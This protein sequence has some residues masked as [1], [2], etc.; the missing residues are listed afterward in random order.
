MN[1]LFCRE[2]TIIADRGRKTIK[3][4]VCRNY[5]PLVFFDIYY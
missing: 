2:K 1:A 5:K 4:V 3:N